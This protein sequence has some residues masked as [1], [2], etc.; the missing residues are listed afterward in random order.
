MTFDGRLVA[1]IGVLAAIVESGSFARAADALGLSPSG[2]S[3]ALARLEQRIGVR[4]LERTTRS[5]ALTDEGRRLYAEIGPLLSGIEDVVAGASGAAGAVRGRL[6]VNV[7]AFFSRHLLAPHLPRFLDAHPELALELVARD[8]LGDL[9][10]DGFDLAVRFGEP[11]ASSLVSRKLLETRTATLAAP[12]YLARM[13]RPAQPADL[14]AHACIQM[15]HAQTGEPLPW[16]FRRGA[17]TLTV[18]TSGRLAVNEV[19]ALM[20][21]CLAGVGVAR[22]KA[23]G[24]Q[25]LIDRGELVDLFPDWTG[26]TFPLY[27]LYPSRHL[28][29]AKTRAFVDFVAQI[30]KG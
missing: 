17:E 7:D 15:R 12:A 26:E 28:P 19:G 20:G 27:A 1:N 11:P 3:R 5:L 13:G 25:D 18:P 16:T 30:V 8:Q 9:I 24:V 22:V 23:I 6:R 10:G 2:V 14:A 29:A 4:L 21:A